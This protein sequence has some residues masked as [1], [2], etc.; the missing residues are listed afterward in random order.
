MLFVTQDLQGAAQLLLEIIREAP[1]V[2][3][4]YHTLGLIYEQ[5]G[6][7]QQALQVFVLA[8]HF[9]P[10]D[11]DMWRRLAMMAEYADPTMMA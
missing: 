4:P 7:Q 1:H 9:T 6:H 11:V 10:R 3:S 2:A 8:A 5:L